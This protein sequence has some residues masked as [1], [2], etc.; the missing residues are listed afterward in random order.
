VKKIL[1][2]LLFITIAAYAQQTS[3]AV[4][5]SEGDA[6]VFNDD[7]LFAL[8]DKL[9][10]VAL[11]T[12]PR[13]SFTLLTQDVVV[14]RLGGAENFIK[15]CRESSCIVDLGK[16]AM[17]DYV[18]QANIGKLRNKMRIRVE[19]YDVATSGL[20]GMYDGNGEYFDDYF[21][22]L[23]AVEKNVPDI[24]KKIPGVVPG[25][26]KAAPIAPAA[27]AANSLS[28]YAAPTQ[29]TPPPQQQPAPYVSPKN[30]YLNSAP[31]QQQ[32][33]PSTEPKTKTKPKPEPKPESESEE[34][35][36]NGIRVGFGLNKATVPDL[37]WTQSAG[38][39]TSVGYFRNIPISNYLSVVAEAGFSYRSLVNMSNDMDIGEINIS[40]TEFALST[41]GML[42]LGSTF[43][44]A[45]GMQIDVPFMATI[46]TT[47]PSALELDDEPQDYDDRAAFDLGI[48]LEAG[49]QI[50]RV[51]L[52]LRI[53]FGLTDID[54]YDT[55]PNNQYGIGVAYLF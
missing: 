55:S 15:E 19:V 12:L 18:A 25:Q 4:L 13:E 26:P 9:R 27:P 28:Q 35:Y 17:V 37:D 7:D 5:P 47:Y 36:L 24:F 6:T 53:V 50:K 42:K 10:S 14:K 2:P 34:P 45:A 52:S 41:I 48:A 33:P 20:V 38:L 3:V 1:L 32:A 51:A 40:E 43:Y 54:S 21:Q 22:L 11:K 16:K 46:T 44:A 31:V 39:G 29:P 8:T 30:A 49:L 23:D